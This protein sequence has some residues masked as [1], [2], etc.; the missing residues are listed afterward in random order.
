MKS[1]DKKIKSIFDVLALGIIIY[2]L[3]DFVLRDVFAKYLFNYDLTMSFICLFTVINFF[4]YIKIG[5]NKIS[6]VEIGL[7]FSLFALTILSLGFR[8]ETFYPNRSVFYNHLIW[9]FLIYMYI[10]FQENEVEL[11]KKANKIIFVLL[12]ACSVI[13]FLSFILYIIETVFR[14]DLNLQSWNGKIG[15]GGR[16]VGVLSNPNPLGH[17]AFMGFSSSLYLIQSFRV[18]KLKMIFGTVAIINL[19]IIILTDCRSAIIAVVVVLIC[20]FFFLQEK[21]VFKNKW[22]KPSIVIILGI[23][24]LFAGYRVMGLNRV[25]TLDY[26]NNENITEVL[27]K[28]TSYRYGIWVETIELGKENIL[29]GNG[30]GNLQKHAEAVYESDSALVKMNVGVPH[31]IFL[32]LYYSTGIVGFSVFVIYLI[33]LLKKLIQLIRN[34]LDSS[35]IFLVAIVL[36]SFS[37]SLL[38]VGVLFSGSISPMFWIFSAIIITKSN[39]SLTINEKD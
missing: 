7:L 12:I 17:I 39:L 1:S 14:Y 5:K 4:Y 28:V 36:G 33:F 13:S 26:F 29:L 3:F 27:N 35:T 32:E 24:M 10:R 11:L 22:L 16:F 8:Y 20:L 30:Y 15:M 21:I 18:L 38:D 19:Y 23:S 6:F 2:Y 34:K 37:I 31:N 25:K 9:I